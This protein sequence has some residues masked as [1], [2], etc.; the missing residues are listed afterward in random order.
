[1]KHT[2][3]DF[4]T[5]Y[6]GLFGGRWPVLKAALQRQPESAA[7]SRG[8]LAPYYLDAAS[9]AAAFCLGETGNARVLDM[10][11]AP[12]GKT[13]ILASTL[14]P[15]GSITA[16]ERSASRRAR[17]IRVLDEHLPHELRRR[18]GVT[19]HDAARWGL[20]EQN[21]YD[22]VLLDAPCSSE[23]H[24]LLNPARLESWSPARIA[25]LA[26]QSYAMLLAALAAAKPGGRVLYSTCALCAGENDEVVARVLKRRPGLARPAAA[27]AVLPE[28]FAG[29]HTLRAEQAEFG[30]NILPDTSGGAGPIYF[31]LLKKNDDA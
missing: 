23:R 14:G 28:G 19:G 11:A 26:R 18:V 16:N 5:F 13:L 21:A 4:D 6:S 7:F 10:C 25:H 27:R 29:T 24:L 15:A 22:L 30:A 1:M 3:P 12:G 9:A 17:L 31:A 2:K 20:Y 8:L